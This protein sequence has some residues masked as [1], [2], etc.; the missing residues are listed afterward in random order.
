MRAVVGTKRLSTASS[1]NNQLHENQRTRS[2]GASVGSSS[3]RSAS[4]SVAQDFF[5]G[6]SIDTSHVLIHPSGSRSSD[7]MSGRLIH[8]SESHPSGS[9]KGSSVPGNQQNQP[10][11]ALPNISSAPIRNLQS[12]LNHRGNTM[13]KGN[14]AQ[15]TS[16]S[17]DLSPSTL[18]SSSQ[19]QGAGGVP[20]TQ[21]KASGGP[22]QISAP[23]GPKH[24]NSRPQV[25]NNMPNR[26]PNRNTAPSSGV[27]PQGPS[28]AATQVSF[29]LDI[30]RLTLIFA[31]N[32]SLEQISARF[33]GRVSDIRSTIDQ[34]QGVPIVTRN[35]IR[36]QV[37]QINRDFDA[38]EHR[39][40][41]EHKKLHREK[42]RL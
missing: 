19:N 36:Q 4:P 30:Q 21:N 34:S 26:G 1:Y 32:M 14:L 33:R 23:Q 41:D 29:Q 20:V 35:Q 24:N 7:N 25:P 8:S 2:E 11:P 42:E 13:N 5:F 38:I 39:S 16:K 40:Q 15:G 37:E 31:Q 17:S 12:Q 27:Q 28:Q 9:I 6:P 22:S 3:S 18:S 10:L